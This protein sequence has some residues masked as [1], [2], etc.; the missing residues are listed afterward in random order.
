MVTD[1]WPLLVPPLGRGP[2][3]TRVLGQS[4][5][6]P[7]VLTDTHL[8]PAL[9]VPCVPGVP[10]RGSTGKELVRAHPFLSC[11]SDGSPEQAHPHPPGL[12]ADPASHEEP[13]NASVR[14]AGGEPLTAVRSVITG[15]RLLPGPGASGWAGHGPH[16]W[17]D[18][19]PQSDWAALMGRAPT[20]T[21]PGS[22]ALPSCLTC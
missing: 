12:R 19:S 1:T 10:V 3:P 7:G 22:A 4:G 2:P 16:R 18:G 17:G 21:H 13:L 6:P 20:S 5:R 15:R 14:G 8:R 11:G 9:V